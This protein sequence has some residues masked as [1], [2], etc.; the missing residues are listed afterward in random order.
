MRPLRLVVLSSA[1]LGCGCGH[2][3]K[4]P[5][6]KTTGELTIN[7][8]VPVGAII[9][10][11]PVAGDFDKQ[12]SRPAARVLE[13]G[14]FVVSTYATGDG[15]PLGEYKAS[16]IWPQFPG[17]DDPGEDRMKGKYSNPQSTPIT[18]NVRIGEATLEPINLE[19]VSLLPGK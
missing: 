10:L 17:R 1:L 7:G 19:N 3:P 12:G 18:V 13:N 4:I 16:I 14:S 2:Q 5:L 15:A 6:Q 9:G 8:V 11:H